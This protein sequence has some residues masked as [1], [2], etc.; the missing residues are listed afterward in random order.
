[1]TSC[2]PNQNQQ[3]VQLEYIIRTRLSYSQIE[4]AS[5]GGTYFIFCSGSAVISI[6]WKQHLK[7]LLLNGNCRVLQLTGFVISE[8]KPRQSTKGN[9]FHKSVIYI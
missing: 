2:F 6:I 8:T 5:C 4:L 7:H 1:M 9:F 3:I